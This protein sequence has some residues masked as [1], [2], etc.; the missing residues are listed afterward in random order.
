M[1]DNLHPSRIVVGERSDRARHFAELLQ[2][3]AIKKEIK[4]ILTESTEEEAIKLLSNSYLAMR[5]AF[6][7]EVDTFSEINELNSKDIIDGMCLDPR[8]GNH[9][10]NP[11]FGYGGYCLPKDIRQLRSC[12]HDI[13]NSIINA[14]VDANTIR[15]NFISN[16]IAKRKPEVVG[17]YRLTMESQSDNFR[18][19]STISI[20]KHLIAKNIR[21]IVYE[22][23]LES[24]RF[25]EVELIRDV[26]EFKQ[27]AD[28]IMTNRVS[29]D[30][31]DVI[32]KVYS[33]DIYL[34]D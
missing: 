28:I 24:D 12:Y 6:F 19:S 18:E 34:R 9:Y 10:N 26:A 29:P 15:K 5:I 1:Y 3:G 17:I 30:L 22:P 7:N 21:V 8:I 16:S 27:R 23:L 11:S 20:I 2:Q 33:R 14:I 4:V 25:I 13:P 32:D 31:S